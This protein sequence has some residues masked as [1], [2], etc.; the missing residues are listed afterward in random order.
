MTRPPVRRAALVA[1]AAL[2]GCGGSGEQTSERTEDPRALYEQALRD[3]DDVGSG[4]LEA[5][6]EARLS[7]GATQTLRLT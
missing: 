3:L 4:T 7:F 2:A 1:L 5:D 6:L